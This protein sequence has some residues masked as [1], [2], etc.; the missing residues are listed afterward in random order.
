[1][2]TAA[3]AVYATVSPATLLAYWLDKRA[4]RTGRRRTPERT[5]HLLELSGGWP[6]A[7]LAWRLFHHTSSKRSYQAVMWLIVALHV[8]VWVVAIVWL[9]QVRVSPHA[10]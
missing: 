6:G 1:M 3:P 9:I 8:L 7:L 2:I 4:A 5:L 10:E